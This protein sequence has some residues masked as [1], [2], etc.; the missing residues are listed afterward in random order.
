M[1]RR[2]RFEQL[3][4]NSHIRQGNP[5]ADFTRH[6]LPTG[7]AGLDDALGGGWPGGALIEFL[8]DDYGVGE[9][10]VLLPALITLS[11]RQLDPHKS[12]PVEKDKWIMLVAPP[13]QPYAPALVR[14]GMNISR[15]LVSHSRCENDILW[16]TEQALR[17]GSCAAVLGWS[18]VAETR[19]L[20]RLQ[21]AAEAGN[22]R[23]V[24][25]RPSRF[26][27]QRSPAA[28]RIYLQ[29]VYGTSLSLDIFKNRG[30][31]PCTVVISRH[32]DF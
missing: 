5:D 8:V 6:F 29:P 23:A 19:R 9:L 17:S 3:L 12:A 25:F 1:S 4:E 10:S 14:H 15:L 18:K 21:L 16:A 27:A 22:S 11:D 32:V 20:R 28:L 24:L 31:R 7:F 2:H 13:Y 30:G 26:R